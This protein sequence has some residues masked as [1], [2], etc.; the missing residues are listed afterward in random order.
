MAVI[1]PTQQRNRVRGEAVKTS[2]LKERDVKLIRLLHAHHILNYSQ[3]AALYQVYDT[4]IRDAAI[5]ESWR[6]VETINGG[7]GQARNNGN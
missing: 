6:H 7:R 1:I 3:L 5:G 2:K 4:T